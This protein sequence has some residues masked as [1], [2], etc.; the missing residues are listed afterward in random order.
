M[1]E[2]T[3]YKA[4]TRYRMC[5]CGQILSIKLEINDDAVNSIHS[6]SWGNVKPCWCTVDSWNTRLTSYLGV[7]YIRCRQC[8]AKRL[9][10]TFKA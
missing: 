1:S 4:E 5:E 10:S 3:K 8:K 2:Q 7:I 9:L 6:I